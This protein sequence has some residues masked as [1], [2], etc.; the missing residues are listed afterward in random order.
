MNIFY[1]RK[2]AVFSFVLIFAAILSGCG[3]NSEGIVAKV[4]DEEI[5]QE[6]FD[7][8]FGFYRDSYERQL[9]EDALTQVGSDG[10]TLENTIKQMVL[11]TLIVEKLIIK[12][13][14][15]KNIVVTDEEVDKRIEE[16][17]GSLGGEDELNGFLE[18]NSMTIE[19]FKKY[20]KNDILFNKHNEDFKNKTDISDKEAK[21]FFEEN[22]EELVIVRASHILLST[23]EDA[24]RVLKAIKKGD[25]FE[26]LAVI[27]SKDST[28]AINGGDLGYIV[29]G[30][31]NAVQEFE[32]A[33][34]SLEVG[35]ISEVIKTEVGFHIILVKERKDTFEELKN[36]IIDILKNQ[37]YASYIEQ[38]K[39]NGK[40][41]IYM[42]IS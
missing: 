13:S 2:L 23:E 40:I 29:K 7:K 18:S 11:D 42:E 19:Y 32:K 8:E 36:E 31:Y 16:L 39:E 38:L 21:D 5:T 12:D 24:I 9:G 30:K 3:K 1:G 34:F 37:K 25:S 27:E 15:S 41:K 10:K 28:S 4:S 6:E 33:V 17:V 14:A 26:E 20:T 35:E 22:K